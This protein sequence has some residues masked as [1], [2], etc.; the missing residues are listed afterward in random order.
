MNQKSEGDLY[1][2]IYIYIYIYIRSICKQQQFRSLRANQR[3]SDQIK[4]LKDQ[5]A[6]TTTRAV[7]VHTHT[8]THIYIYIYI[9]II[10]IYIYMIVKQSTKILASIYLYF[11]ILHLIIKEAKCCLL[12]KLSSYYIYTY[13]CLNIIGQ[14]QEFSAIF[15]RVLFYTQIHRQ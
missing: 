1:E 10:Y 7:G 14:K 13:G 9:Y 2:H 12:Q 11:I 3:S 4:I 15:A 5:S 6:H 8:H